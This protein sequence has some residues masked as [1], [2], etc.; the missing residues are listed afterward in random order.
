MSSSLSNGAVFGALLL[1][2]ILLVAAYY[3][4]GKKN[5]RIL[6]ATAGMLEE[7]LKPI[8]KTYTW[9]GG[10]IGFK[11]EYRVSGFEKVE[12]LVTVLPR[13]SLL[14][15][16]FALLRGS[17]DRLEMVFFLKNG[18][19][20]EFHLIKED[21]LKRFSAIKEKSLKEIQVAGLK[22]YRVFTRKTD[23]ST[24]KAMLNRIDRIFTPYLH[25]LA[26]MPETKRAFLSLQIPP[27][28]PS[29]VSKN[30]KAIM[31]Q[32]RVG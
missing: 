30:I 17:R 15:M 29:S 21:E 28:T 13:Q 18:P 22:G 26:L 10:T 24:L 32:M 14:Y 5:L 8:D 2:S 1:F 20:G 3:R 27:S 25:H 16:P 9:L 6:R 19:E 12:A 7:T 11:A 4:G 31:R 23:G